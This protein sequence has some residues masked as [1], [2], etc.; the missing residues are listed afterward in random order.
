MKH[1]TYPYS[2]D[3][4]PRMP[5][6]TVTLKAPSSGEAIGPEMA[7]VD[8]GADGTLIPINLLEQIGAVSIATG[9]LTWL[10]EESRPVNLYIVQMEIGPCVLPKVRVAGVPAGT[11]LILGRNVLNQMVLTLNGPAGVMEIPA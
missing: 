7:L 5:V 10:W 3:Y 9:R 4:E 8:S 1:Y 11:D 6:A 2:V